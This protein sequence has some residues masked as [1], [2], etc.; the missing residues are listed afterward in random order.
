MSYAFKTSFRAASFNSDVVVLDL[1]TDRFHIL[2]EVTSERLNS[3]L[4]G[5]NAPLAE[6]LQSAGYIELSEA[7]TCIPPHVPMG[8]FEVRWMMPIVDAAP[9][10][11]ERFEAA[12]EVL[13]T[14]RDLKHASMHDV[15]RG[16]RRAQS[17]SV[18]ETQDRGFKLNALIAALN[19]AFALD[20]TGNKCL[21]YSY[22]LVRLLRRAGIS[23]TLVIGVRTKPFVSHA[24]VECDDEVIGDDRCLRAK[25]SVIMEG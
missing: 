21:A 1:S 10:W 16:I 7:P 4:R 11:K 20:R 22:S 19:K 6:A 15:F 9:T 8:M 24:W 18:L 14:N 25:L 3:A 23:A 13:K 17:A 5:E 2:N 12:I